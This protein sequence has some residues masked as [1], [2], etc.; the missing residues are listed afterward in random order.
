MKGRVIKNNSGVY[1]IKADNNYYEAIG[2]GKLRYMK[3][4]TKSE[5]NKNK[6]FKTKLENKRIKISPKVGDIVEFTNSDSKY[7]ITEVMP[8]K[9]DLTR[10][11]VSNVDQIILIF[12]AKEPDFD[13]YLLDQFIVLM[14]K[15]NVDI[16]IVITKI[17]L[18]KNDELIKLKDI[19]TYYESIGY[20]TYLISN[21]TKDGIEEVKDLFKDK[22][23][24]LSGQTGAG[25]SNS[26]NNLIEGFNLKTGEI[27]YALGRGRHTTRV[28]ELFEFQN[29][30]IGD[31]PG[32]SKLSFM[33]L[34]E[35]ELKYYFK[36]FKNEECYFNSCMHDK[37]KGCQVKQDVL[38][39]KILK[40]RYDN[41]LK[42]YHELSSIKKK[43]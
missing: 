35:K 34:D 36:E 4:D 2:S 28:S 14:E 30:L 17:D 9:N 19:K 29:G 37:E 22:I 7:V 27:S 21:K 8:R 32:F 26:I 5:F 39:G 23:S 41:Y 10:P 18:L 15:E 42:F 25:K 13:T 38:D 33:I 6:T 31:T 24:I 40:S 12:S 1:T 3:V 11:L 43:Y 16:K 20:P